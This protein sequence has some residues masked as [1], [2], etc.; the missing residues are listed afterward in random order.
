MTNFV[1]QDLESDVLISQA[2]L[3]RL[4]LKWKEIAHAHFY[5][6]KKT[7]KD[8]HEWLAIRVSVYTSSKG[9]ETVQRA[10]SNFQIFKS[11]GDISMFKWDILNIISFVYILTYV[12][13]IYELE[14]PLHER[15]PAFQE[16]S[17]F[18]NAR[19]T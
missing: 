10:N 12:D 18:S 13:T 19:K 7:P 11:K 16:Q 6:S 17:K 9:D 4:D 8:D 1:E 14:Y 3:W 2:R 15:C 5:W